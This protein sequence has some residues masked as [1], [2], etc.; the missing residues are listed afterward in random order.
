MASGWE[1]PSL[2]HLS[3][4]LAPAQAHQEGGAE[5]VQAWKGCEEGLGWGRKLVQRGEG[6][7]CLGGGQQRDGDGGG[8]G[9][10]DGGRWGS[11]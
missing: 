2:P 1:H 7:G 8:G 5:G 9:R 11:L 4:S 3:Q 10:C 6:R